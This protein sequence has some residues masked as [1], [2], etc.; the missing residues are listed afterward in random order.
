MKRYA[1][2]QARRGYGN[3][4]ASA[5]NMQKEL[6][7]WAQDSGIRCMQSCR[8]GSAGPNQACPSNAGLQL[9]LCRAL[10]PRPYLPPGMEYRAFERGPAWPRQEY[11]TC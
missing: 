4:K 5:R 7:R 2:K 1:G 11:R 3:I 10:A 6:Q 9:S 8:S